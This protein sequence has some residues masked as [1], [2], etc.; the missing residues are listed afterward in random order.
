MLACAFLPLAASS[1]GKELCIRALM[2]FWGPSPMT[3]ANPD[4]LPRARLQTPPHRGLGFSTG[5]IQS[6]AA[7]LSLLAHVSMS[8]LT[9]GHPRCPDTL[10][11][12]QVLPSTLTKRASSLPRLL[13]VL[14]R[15]RENTSPLLPLSGKFSPVHGSY[16]CLPGLHWNASP[17]WAIPTAQCEHTSLPQ[18]SD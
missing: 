11:V 4:H 17:R 2:P 9:P 1:W 6:S 18:S 10:S 8:F 16:F 12:S 14:G 13:Q 5:R 15:D 3:S 7:R